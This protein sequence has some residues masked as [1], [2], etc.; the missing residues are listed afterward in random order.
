MPFGFTRN[1]NYVFCLSD[2]FLP[3]G[4]SAAITATSARIHRQI[5]TNFGYSLLHISARCLPELQRNEYRT[6]VPISNISESVDGTVPPPS[7]YVNQLPVT[8]PRLA[9]SD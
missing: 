4:I 2:C 1:I 3:S 9:A 5:L 7:S 8:T 6:L